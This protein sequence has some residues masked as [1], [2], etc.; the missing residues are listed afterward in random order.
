[1]VGIIY[2]Y[3]HND[4]NAPFREQLYYFWD[5]GKDFLFSASLYVT[6][7]GRMKKVFLIISLCML[8]R[9]MW[10]LLEFINYDYA[11]NV[12]FLNWLFLTCGISILCINI[13]SI[14]E[15]KKQGKKNGRT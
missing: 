9:L 8:I 13:I 10:Q 4:Y 12:K 15:V 14:R 3:F 7:K 5:K 11:N 2:L 6:L 1:M